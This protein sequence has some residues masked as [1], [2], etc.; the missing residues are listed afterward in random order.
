MG[1]RLFLIY[2]A[3]LTGFVIY[4]VFGLRPGPSAADYRKLDED[5]A[6]YMG[7]RWERAPELG[8][9][10][11]GTAFD[12]YVDSFR[13]G[14]T[15]WDAPEMEEA[16]EETDAAIE[17]LRCALPGSEEEPHPRLV[18]RLGVGS[19]GFD[20]LI[21]GARARVVTP[22]PWFLER[23][24]VG[25]QNRVAT[26]MAVSKL[27][28]ASASILVREGRPGLAVDR[29]V[30][31]HRFG[32]DLAS[33][34]AALGGLMGLSFSEHALLRLGD[35]VAFGLLPPE[36]VR[37]V[38]SWAGRLP[39]WALPENKVFAGALLELRSEILYDLWSDAD[40]IPFAEEVLA[41]L[42]LDRRS[43]GTGR[44]E[45]LR[46]RTLPRELEK[47]F[48][49]ESEPLRALSRAASAAPPSAPIQHTA[50]V[51]P[52]L[53][54]VEGEYRDHLRGLLLGIDLSQERERTGALP[55]GLPAGWTLKPIPGTTELGL[56]PPGAGP[57]DW[58]FRM[59][60]SR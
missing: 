59:P 2:M 36:E 55:T 39:C 15:F 9:G 10:V 16:W 52:A 41:D 18:A 33:G 13:W 50:V 45:Y 60:A 38:R 27:V 14:E 48:G 7:Q 43:M 51:W 37:R 29:L 31:L 40:S 57:T 21:R 53:L 22:P 3:G 32:L 42:G 34:S 19:P 17:A 58:V 26:A 6:A 24:Q 28:S 23:V 5:I 49:G 20:G 25:G 44:R 30:A 11:E 35:L 54:R 8:G 46:L 56:Y 4:A 1:R 12:H 47:R